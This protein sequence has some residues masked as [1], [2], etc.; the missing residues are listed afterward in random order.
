M[1][2]VSHSGKVE[3]IQGLVKKDDQAVAIDAG[4][5]TAS[6]HETKTTTPKPAFTQK[7]MD[8][9]KAIRL[10]A[11][12][13]AMLEKPDF[14]LD[15]LAFALSPAS[16]YF[17]DVL[18]LRI[19]PERNAPEIDDMFNLS[20]RIGGAMTEE[21]EVANDELENH[22]NG[23]MSEKFAAYRK[24]SKKGRNAQITQSFA[25]SLQSQ[26]PE[27]M[28]EIEAEVGADIRSI[29]TPT[30]SNCFKRLN[31]QQL[32]A[33]YMDFLDLKPDSAQFKAFSNAKKS[34]KVETMHKVFH[35]PEHQKLRNIT[36]EQKK[37]IDAWVPDCL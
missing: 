3:T 28:A 18:G 19:I 33:L 30:A 31:G 29:W 17:S 8:D 35:D 23:T 26:K 2:Y 37:R 6:A 7:F 32:D 4:V 25:R 27:F 36:P 14:V 13:T 10:A 12:Q 15:L 11:V 5:L 34:E 24:T 20:S 16:G 1:V 21:E 22:F 9:M